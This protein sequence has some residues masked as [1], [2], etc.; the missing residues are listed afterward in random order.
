M[1]ESPPHRSDGAQVKFVYE[2]DMPALAADFYP[3]ERSA[4]V[5][6]WDPV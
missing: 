6:N 2:R 3:L 1:N 5:F 4:D